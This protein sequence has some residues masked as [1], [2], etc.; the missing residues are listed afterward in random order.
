M[1]PTLNPKSAEAIGLILGLP[2]DTVTFFHDLV[3]LGEPDEGP[4]AHWLAD[5]IILAKL[6][7]RAEERDSVERLEQS[8]SYL[9]ECFS[10]EHDELLDLATD[11]NTDFDSFIDFLN[12]RD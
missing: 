2:G 11:P 7:I 10:P 12:D 9:S 4:F 1:K 3:W 5:Q 8:W 6:V